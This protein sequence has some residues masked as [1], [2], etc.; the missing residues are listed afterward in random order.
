MPSA[1]ADPPDLTRLGHPARDEGPLVGAEPRHRTAGQ[2]H[3]DVLETAVDVI[4]DLIH[5]RRHQVEG[6]LDVRVPVEQRRHLVIV[7][8]AAEPNPGQQKTAG[9]VILVI[10]LVHVPDEGH[11][12]RA[13]HGERV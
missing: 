2:I 7:L 6:L 4:L 1:V 11:M 5:Q 12:Q 10:R 13:R 9:Q 8:G 3:V